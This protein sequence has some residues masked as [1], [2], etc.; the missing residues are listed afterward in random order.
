[1]ENDGHAIK[2][3]IGARLPN[4]DIFHG[5]LTLD[6]LFFTRPLW[7]YA[8]YRMPVP[9][10]YVCGSGAHLAASQEHRDTTRAQVVIAELV[11]RR[12]PVH[13]VNRQLAARDAFT[14]VP[15]RP[16]SHGASAYSQRSL[17]SAPPISTRFNVHDLSEV[18][19]FVLRPEQ[20]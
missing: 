20:R 19:W 13:R 17:S 11:R 4:G 1:M 12:A 8:D 7:G 3:S 2:C 18:C 5:A 16:L 9:G 14:L 10:I 15:H 6:Q